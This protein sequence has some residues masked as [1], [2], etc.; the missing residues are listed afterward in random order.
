MEIESLTARSPDLD[1][2]DDAGQ[3]GLVGSLER[4]PLF[5]D[6]HSPSHSLHSLEVQKMGI[7]SSVNL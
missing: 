6:Y 7:Q 3:M 1:A 2:R 4:E 5:G